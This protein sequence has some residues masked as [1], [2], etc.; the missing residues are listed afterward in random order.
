MHFL[1]SW[2]GV[3]TSL[4][5]MLDGKL[6]STTH[7]QQIME[8]QSLGYNMQLGYSLKLTA[9][10]RPGTERSALV[11]VAPPI[12]FVSVLSCFLLCGPGLT[13][14]ILLHPMQCKRDRGKVLPDIF[15][16]D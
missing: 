6:L 2:L 7:V 16:K 5:G 12:V 10:S 8:K 4:F 14:I 3:A 1:I 9:K 15:S 13:A 11:G